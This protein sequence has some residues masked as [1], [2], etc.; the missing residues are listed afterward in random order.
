MA[1]KDKDSMA[2][3]KSLPKKMQKLLDLW[4][5]NDLHWIDPAWD[6]EPMSVE[7]N[8][9]TGAGE[10]MYIN[11]H[12]IS[13]DA[14]EEYVNDFD[15]NENVSLWWPDGQKGRGVPFDNQAEQVQDYEDYLAWLRDIIDLSRG[16]K[17]KKGELSRS[18]EL[19]V[20]KFMAAAKD[21]EDVGVAI[22]WSKKKGFTFKNS[23]ESNKL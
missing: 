22:T 12:E 21:L 10:D 16:I 14:L 19:Y 2:W 23:A 9:S 5:E 3:Y 7:L 4:E 11:L 18:Q 1:N 13:A 20:E 17:R 15:I 8:C 6:D